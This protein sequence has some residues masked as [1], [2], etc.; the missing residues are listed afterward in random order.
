MTL[1]TVMSEDKDV[2]LNQNDF[3][4]EI[5]YSSKDGTIVSS[6]ITAILSPG[7]RLAQTDYGACELVTAIIDVDDVPTPSIYDTFIYG[8]VKYTV[9]SRNNGDLGGFWE[10]IAEADQ[11][12][13][14]RG[15]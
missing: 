8:S 9:R 6:A 1:K 5:S 10:I 11:R 3:A 4:V 15:I 7:N 2:F 14:P 12:Q 13:K